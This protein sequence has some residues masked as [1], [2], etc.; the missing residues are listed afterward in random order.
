V[1]RA[2]LIRYSAISFLVPYNALEVVQ[3]R[4]YT[5]FRYLGSVSGGAAV[6]SAADIGSAALCCFSLNPYFEVFPEPE[7]RCGSY[8]GF[9]GLKFELR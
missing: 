2:K 5:S 3:R 9:S 8:A 6:M 1:S 7:V 4:S